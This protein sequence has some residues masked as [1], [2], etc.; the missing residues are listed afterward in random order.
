MPTNA[1]TLW[2]RVGASLL[3]PAAVLASAASAATQSSFATVFV[4]PSPL[5]SPFL[6]ISL[7]ALEVNLNS[8]KNIKLA[9]PGQNTYSINPS[10]P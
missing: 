9:G 3:I 7:Q 1:V 5:L 2:A 4:F 6:P 8:D 10:L